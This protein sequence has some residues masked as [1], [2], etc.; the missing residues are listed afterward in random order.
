[1]ARRSRLNALSAGVVFVAAFG[2]LILYCA[3]YARMWKVDSEYRALQEELRSLEKQR[4]EL[5]GKLGDLT[6][7]SHIEQ[8]AGARGMIRDPGPFVTLTAPVSSET[9]S[10]AAIALTTSKAQRH[11]R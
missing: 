8:F 2:L 4:Q 10:L 5:D 11:T 3:G 9:A 1:M 6:S 7:P